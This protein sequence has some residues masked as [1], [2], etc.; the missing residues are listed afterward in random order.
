MSLKV[1]KVALLIKIEPFCWN[2]QEMLCSF[3]MAAI[4]TQHKPG[5]LKLQPFILTVKNPYT[6]QPRARDH[7]ILLSSSRFQKHFWDLSL[8]L[9]SANLSLYSLSMVQISGVCLSQ[10]CIVFIF[11]HLCLNVPYFMMVP[12]SRLTSTVILNDQNLT[13]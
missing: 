4:T 1:G 3:P 8:M 6:S 11:L 13:F 9:P 12:V 5:C 2:N 10:C 7:L